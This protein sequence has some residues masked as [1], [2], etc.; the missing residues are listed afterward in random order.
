MFWSGLLL[1]FRLGDK[2]RGWNGFQAIVPIKVCG[3]V[4]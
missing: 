4:S 3:V 2:R 1:T